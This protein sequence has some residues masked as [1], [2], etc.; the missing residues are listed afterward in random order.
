MD[1]SFVIFECL[2]I[3]ATISILF[4]WFVR[5]EN[6]RKEF[7]A[8]NFPTW[9]R[10]LIGILK[11]SFI[12]ML[13]SNINQVV[14]IGATGITILMLGAVFTHFRVKNDFRRYIASIMMLLMCSFIL[15]YSIIK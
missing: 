15:Y 1:Y 10:D 14:T 6:I 5:Y 13:H 9:F 8:Y 4:V 7:E 11:I 2:K 3:I 12:I